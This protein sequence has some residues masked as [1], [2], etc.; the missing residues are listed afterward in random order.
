[1]HAMYAY[2]HHLVKVLP[3][4]KLNTIEKLYINSRRFTY[5]YVFCLR[6]ILAARFKLLETRIGDAFFLN[7]F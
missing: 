1:M 4:I 6:N 2:K 7:I 5:I 3:R